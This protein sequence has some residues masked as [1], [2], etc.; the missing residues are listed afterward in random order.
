[1]LSFDADDDAHTAADIQWE[2]DVVVGVIIISITIIIIF[3]FFFFFFFIIVKL[4]SLSSKIQIK[5]S[6]KLLSG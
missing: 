6:E 1:M 4:L 5:R 3:F 2:S